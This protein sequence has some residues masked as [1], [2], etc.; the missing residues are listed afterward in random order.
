[1]QIVANMMAL[2]EPDNIE[3]TVDWAYATRCAESIEAARLILLEAVERI[4]TAAILH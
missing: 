4:P 1:M 2:H 3:W